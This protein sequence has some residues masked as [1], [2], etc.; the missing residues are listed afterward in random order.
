MLTHANEEVAD[1]D[2]VTRW[3]DASADIETAGST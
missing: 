3:D 1:G 2:V